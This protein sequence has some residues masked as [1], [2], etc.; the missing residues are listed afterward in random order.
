MDEFVGSAEFPTVPEIMRRTAWQ[1][2]FIC[3]NKYL[4][5]SVYREV[6]EAMRLM[7]IPD[8]IVTI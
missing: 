5:L 3:N 6:R 7:N 8:L 2:G 4:E 1:E